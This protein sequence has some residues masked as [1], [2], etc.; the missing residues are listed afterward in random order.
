[1][2]DTSVTVASRNVSEQAPKAGALGA[3]GVRYI[4]FL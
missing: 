2:N 4:S 3:I 1:M